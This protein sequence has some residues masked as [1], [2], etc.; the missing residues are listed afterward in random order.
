MANAKTVTPEMKKRSEAFKAGT[1][2]IRN[3]SQ[4]GREVLTR[5]LSQSNSAFS[6]KQY[7]VALAKY[8]EAIALDPTNA[9]LYSNRSACYLHI[10]KWEQALRDATRAVELDPKFTKAMIRRATAMTNLQRPG[11]ASIVYR[12]ILILDPGNKVAKD[13][14]AKINKQ[15]K[16]A[17]VKGNVSLVPKEYHPAGKVVIGGGILYECLFCHVRWCG[18]VV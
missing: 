5:V 16:D 15:V 6:L 8:T 7:T 18:E 11:D 13:E 14:L 10:K 2:H 12:D 9:V 17:V 1:P 3:P 4:G